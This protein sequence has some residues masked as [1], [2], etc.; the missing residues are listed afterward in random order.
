M[1]MQAVFN[2]KVAVFGI[3]IVG[4]IMFGPIVN[5]AIHKGM[6]GTG[7]R[8]LFQS[9]LPRADL[10]DK[11]LDDPIE[12]DVQGKEFT[13]LLLPQVCRKTYFGNFGEKRHPHWARGWLRS[14]LRLVFRL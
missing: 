12:I 1:G 5:T 9:F 14:R 2:A 13:V 10:Y 3:C 6:L 7:T 8:W 4:C 11:L